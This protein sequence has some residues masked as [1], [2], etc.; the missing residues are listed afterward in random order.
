VVGRGRTRF[1]RVRGGARR[2]THNGAICWD[3]GSEAASINRW[4]GTSVRAPNTALGAIVVQADDG[5][6]TLGFAHGEK[7]LRGCLEPSDSPR[8]VGCQPL[9]VGDRPML[10]PSHP[11]AA[12]WRRGALS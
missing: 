6:R 2:A 8:L 10:G 4:T 11:G 5:S 12:I 7:R 9:S 1:L 3:S